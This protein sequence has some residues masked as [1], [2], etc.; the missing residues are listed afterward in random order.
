MVKV[1]N[2]RRRVVFGAGTGLSVTGRGIYVP[3][4]GLFF[5][6]VAMRERFKLQYVVPIAYAVACEPSYLS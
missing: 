2:L 1:M 3:L 6:V 5:S 4:E